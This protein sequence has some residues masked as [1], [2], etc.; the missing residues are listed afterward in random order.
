[1]SLKRTAVAGVAALT[2]VGAALGVAGAQQTPTPSP[3]PSVPATRPPSTQQP[4][5]I[6]PGPGNRGPSGQA[7]ADRQQHHEQFL[8]SLAAKLN[9]TPDRLRQAMEETRTELGLPDRSNGGPGGRGGGRFASLEAAA[10]AIGITADQLRQEL[11]GKTLAEVAQAH[12]V[13]PTTV[14]NALKADANARIDQA[15]AAGR[16]PSDQVAQAKQRAADQIDQK[17]TQQA[18]AAGVPQRGPRS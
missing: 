7:P 10:Q 11:P 3:S 13:S 6:T 17:M 18:P 1:L 5:S 14:A 2:M 4:P 12:N 16:I 8:N 15:A 9:V